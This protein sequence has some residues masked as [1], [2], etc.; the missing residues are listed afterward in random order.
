LLQIPA[1][2]AHHE[3]FLEELRK[4]LEHWDIKQKVGDVFLDVVSK[5]FVFG[6]LNDAFSSLPFIFP[7]FFKN[8]KIKIHETI[9]VPLVLYG[10]EI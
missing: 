8:V 1:I 6:L 3:V 2:L 4:R 9:I 10:C 5:M 7:S